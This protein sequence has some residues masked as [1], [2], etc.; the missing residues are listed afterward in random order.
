MGRIRHTRG[1][2]LCSDRY[3]YLYFF[4]LTGN[5]RYAQECHTSNL[6]GYNFGPGQTPYAQGIVWIGVTDFFHSLAIVEMAIKG[7]T[8]L[9]SEAAAEEK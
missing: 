6:N 3:I 5:N 7:K 2:A 9:T 1:P 8:L 4:C